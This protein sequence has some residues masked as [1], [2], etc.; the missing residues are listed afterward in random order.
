MRTRRGKVGG[1]PV[2]HL[3]HLAADAARTAHVLRT[4]DPGVAVPGCPDWTLRDL[5]THLGQVHRWAAEVVRTGGRAAQPQVQVADAELGDWLAEG[6]AELLQVLRGTEPDRPCWAFAGEQQAS[7]WRRR[8]ALETVVH[9]LDAERAAGDPTPVPADL[10]EDG[11]AEVVDLL[12][13]R[14]VQLG[15]TAAPTKAA[16]LVSTSSGRTWVLGKGAPTATVTGPPEQLLLLLWKR[17][18]TGLQRAGDLTALGDL[19]A[20]RL[21]P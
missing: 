5:G 12:H 15:R 19:L 8:Q 7:F 10:A 1:V 2:D 21:T 9:R 14:Q 11:V 4:A 17:D 16:T 13:A 20:A 18:S 6:A 3:S